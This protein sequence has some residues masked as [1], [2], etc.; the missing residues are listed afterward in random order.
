MLCLE[1][2]GGWEVPAVP[3]LF[4]ARF[5]RLLELFSSLLASGEA[6]S[7]AGCPQAWEGERAVTHLMLNADL[8]HFDIVPGSLETEGLMFEKM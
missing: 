3:F 4:L 6:A 7:S 5:P 2:S 1:N 8:G